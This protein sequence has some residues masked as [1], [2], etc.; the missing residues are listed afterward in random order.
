MRQALNQRTRH[1]QS[2][3]TLNSGHSAEHGVCMRWLE[4]HFDGECMVANAHGYDCSGRMDQRRKQH[5]LFRCEVSLLHIGLGPTT[6]FA[7]TQGI[8]DDCQEKCSVH[9]RVG[10]PPCASF[11]QILPPATPYSVH[12]AHLAG[13]SDNCE[14]HGL[15]GD[16]DWVA[17][18]SLS[19]SDQVYNGGCIAQLLDFHSPS[20]S[21]ITSTKEATT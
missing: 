15:P 16:M 12:H 20:S 4:A 21:S 10:H 3:L 13:G 2:H 18:A 5:L 9:P 6:F 11:R 17:G 19:G 1:A 14:C 7:G 8:Q